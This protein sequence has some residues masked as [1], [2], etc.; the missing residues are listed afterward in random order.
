MSRSS[1]SQQNTGSLKALMNSLLFRRMVTTWAVL[2]ALLLVAVAFA[3]IIA[4][5][6]FY[7]SSEG[8][9]LLS[10]A[11]LIAEVRELFIKGELDMQEATALQA[12]ITDTAGCICYIYHDGIVVTLKDDEL[13][14]ADE[15]DA[16][17]AELSEYAETLFA[18]EEVRPHII[19]IAGREYMMAGMLVEHVDVHSEAIVC[20]N[21]A[22]A[23]RHRQ[24]VLYA[25]FA[26]AIALVV[27][28]GI[29][30]ILRL[31]RTYVLPYTEI[32]NAA[33]EMSHGNLYARVQREDEKGE[34]GLLARTFNRLGAS[35]SLNF[36]QLERERSRLVQ[37]V[38]SS[39]N[40]IAVTDASG[41]LIQYNPALLELFS[42]L[43]KDSKSDISSDRRLMVI[44]DDAVWEHF[45]KVN[46]TG[47]SERVVYPILSSATSSVIVPSMV[48]L[49]RRD[50]T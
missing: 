35:L 41:E 43:R 22:A 32:A 21:S 27:A 39:S 15:D 33:I 45:N 25:A 23:F 19:R 48:R 44:P 26:T 7:T 37:I 20:V 14:L 6:G 31:T 28:T 3:L 13:V 12:R 47:T 18:G 2:S 24:H 34:V 30:I 29:L 1:D 50:I 9:L 11:E 49:D 10:N 42:Q 46:A 4:I 40:G 16:L 36:V 8:E 17:A 5:N 38:N